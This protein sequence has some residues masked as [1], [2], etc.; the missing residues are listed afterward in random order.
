M[1][2]TA[3]IVR[4]PEAEAAVGA[5]REQYDASHRPG[6]PPHI[7]VLYPFM[8][9]EEITQHAL[10][11]ARH[12]LRRVPQFSFELSKVEFFPIS[13][14]LAPSPAEPFEALTRTLVKAFPDYRPWGGEHA[15]IVPN[16]T[17]AHG[18]IGN[19]NVAA[20]AADE[21]LIAHGAIRCTCRDVALIENVYGRWRELCTFELPPRP[22][23]V[24]RAWV[25][26]FNRAD[27]DALA[28]CY[29]EDAVDHQ[30]PEAP[31]QG[32][33]AI[34]A[35]FAAGFASARMLCEPENLFEDGEWSVL[36]WRDPLGLR[37][38]DFFRVVEGL[39]VFQRGYRDRLSFLRAQGLPLPPA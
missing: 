25:E 8:R 32:R 39:I 4:V 23:D 5:L 2:A 35:M 24:V 11:R 33:A 36:E 19:A 9:P 7:T 20:G 28:A 17:I 16:L 27:A 31:V 13:A 21:W 22:R 26:A 18:D 14:Y 10:D 3:F 1:A 12:A 37:G 29:A 38:C 30:V 6:M 15:S 34:R